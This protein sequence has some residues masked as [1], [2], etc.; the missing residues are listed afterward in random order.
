MNTTFAL[1]EVGL[2]GTFEK[3]RNPVRDMKILVKHQFLTLS[4]SGGGADSAL[5]NF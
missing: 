1:Y 2:G 3:N 5:H 4:G